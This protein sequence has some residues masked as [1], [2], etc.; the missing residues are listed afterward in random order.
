LSSKT[1]F[2]SSAVEAGLTT[3][4]LHEHFKYPCSINPQGRYNVPLDPKEGY[5]IE[6]FEESMKEFAF[7]GGTY[8]VA[9]AAGNAPKPK[10]RGIED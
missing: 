3:S 8:W 6:M 5:S 7:P 2:T 9:A 10:H 4:H 1:F